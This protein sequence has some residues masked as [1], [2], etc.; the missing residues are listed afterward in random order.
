MLVNVENLSGSA[1]SDALTGD[2]GIN[3]LDGGAGDDLLNGAGG[4]DTLLGGA[5]ND[6]LI[7]GAGINL[8]DGGTGSDTADYSAQTTAVTVTLM[9]AADGSATGIG[10]SDT[11]RGIENVTGGS[12]NDTIVAD[13]NANFIDGGFG[14]DTV[15]YA[16]SAA[17]VTITLTVPPTVLQEQAGTR[18]VT[19][20]SMSR[21]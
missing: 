13:S 18:Q 8:L 5:G 12:G 9:G 1:G 20:W 2:S 7:G 11:L 17:G 15:S 4:N 16:N 6:T 10:F 14:T 3:V 19:C 21:T